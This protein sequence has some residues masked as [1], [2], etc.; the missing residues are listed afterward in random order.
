MGSQEAN[1]NTKKAANGITYIYKYINIL[2]NAMG[3][4]FLT[5]KTQIIKNK[6]LKCQNIKVLRLIL[7]T[8]RVRI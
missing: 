6:Q 7:T 8:K 5:L 3:S 4:A 2:E 1:F